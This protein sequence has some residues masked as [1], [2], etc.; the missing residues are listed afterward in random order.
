VRS[1]VHS[2]FG[3]LGSFL[4]TLPSF[5]G[6]LRLID[7]LAAVAR[8]SGTS[9]QETLPWS[10]THFLVDLHDRIQRQM[11]CGCYEPHVTQ[12]LEAVLRPGDT[13]LD[14]GANIG[15]HSIFAARCVGEHG[16]VYAFEPDPSLFTQLERNL[17]QFPQAH[18]FP[19]A[20]WESDGPMTF[21][22]SPSASES[23]W[24]SL[25]SVRDF[26]EGEHVQVET[27]SLDSWGSQVK[28]SALRAMKID[29]EG[30]EL[31][32]FRGA[33][34]I[35]AK[36]SPALIL[37]F[38]DVL[39][40]KAGGSAEELAHEVR[41]RGY[42]VYEL[43]SKQLR[44]RDRFPASS[45]AECLCLAEESTGQWLQALSKNGFQV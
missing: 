12:C 38:N 30:S 40:R 37:E 9:E 19:L 2:R 43:F 35:L 13:F 10:G 15:Y 11:W 27:V 21:A 32:V 26:E 29:A 44:S 24:G 18:S 39:L 16:N 4:G 5:P 1:L 31:A 22:R 34:R 36:L 3:R 6:R 41:S 28:L 17:K 7:W 8:W 33:R 23:G 14:V 45:F 25:A 20:I 42:R